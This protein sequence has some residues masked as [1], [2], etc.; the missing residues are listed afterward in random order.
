MTE[1]MGDRARMI[2]I[3]L[4]IVALGCAVMWWYR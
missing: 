4:V 3:S 2:Q 1:I